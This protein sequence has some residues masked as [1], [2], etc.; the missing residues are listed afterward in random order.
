MMSSASSSELR[1]QCHLP[2]PVHHEL[3]EERQQIA[4]VPVADSAHTPQ[5]RAL[6]HQ[7]ERSLLTKPDEADLAGADADVAQVDEGVVGQ[8]DVEVGVRDHNVPEIDLLQCFGTPEQLLPE[9]LV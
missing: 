4:D 5:L 8:D 3:V 7:T 2:S 1:F 9:L 6:L